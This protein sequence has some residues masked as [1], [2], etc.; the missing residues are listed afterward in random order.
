M[1]SRANRRHVTVEKLEAATRE[2]A[3]LYLR[4]DLPRVW[5]DGKRVAAD[6]TQYDFYD[7]NLLAGY[8]LR[9]RPV[10]AVAYRHVANHYIATFRHFIPPAIWEAAYVFEG[11]MQATLSIIPDR[12]SAWR[13]KRGA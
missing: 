13:G 8:Q 6:G 9:Y 12:S 11:M 7:Q 5:G 4:L 3:E 10:G 1:I 2:L